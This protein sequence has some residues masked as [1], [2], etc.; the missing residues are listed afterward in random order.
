VF[1]W[2]CGFQGLAEDLGFH[3]LAAEK[4]LEFADAVLEV[5]DAADGDDLL[6]CPDRLVPTLSHAPPPL[7]QQAGGDA[8]EPGV[9]GG[10]KVGHWS[11]GMMLSRA[12]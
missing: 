9:R 10:E 5:T 7:E 12:A 8:M 11:G 6:V 3:G 1:F 4:A 2:A